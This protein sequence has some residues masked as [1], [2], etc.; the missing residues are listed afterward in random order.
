MKKYGSIRQFFLL[1]IMCCL[2]TLAKADALDALE[3]TLK[4]SP[5]VQ[6]KIYVHT[7]NNMYFVGD[8]LWYK[9]YVVRADNLQPTNM[10][11]LLYV[12][13]LTPD[14][15]LVERQHVVVSAAG[16]TCGQFVLKDS[17]YSGYYEIRAYTRWQLNFNVTEKDYTSD[18]RLKF[19]GKQ[20]AQDF[21]R[22]F[23]G[24]YSRVLPVFEKPKKEGDY[25]DRYMARRPKQHVLKSKTSLV[26]NF[27]PEGGHLVQGVENNVAFEI[28]DNQGQQ[29]DVEGT[30]SD[31]R[32]IRPTHMGR[33]SF[34]VKPDGTQMNVKFEWNGKPVTFRLPQVQKAG[35]V[36]AYDVEKNKATV[37]AT[38]VQPSAYTILCRGRLVKFSRM[39]GAGDINI[40]AEECPTGINEIIVYDQLA[41]P[42]ASRLFFVNHHD[43]GTPVSVG[44]TADGGEVGKTTTL[45]PYAPVELT[46]NVPREDAWIGTMSVAVRD[47]QTDDC[48]YDNG[49]IMTDMLLSSELK[50]FIASPAYY[51]AAD[52]AQ[53]RADLDLLMMVQGW[54]RYKRVEKLRYEPERELAYEGTVFTVPENAD[55][56]ELDDVSNAGSKA[57]TVADQMLAEMDAIS[58]LKGADTFSNVDPNASED[59]ED[60]DAGLGIDPDATNDET[61]EWASTDDIRLG[62]GYVK[63]SVLV[64]AELNKDGEVAGAITHTDKRGHFKITLPAFYDQAI[65]FA[66][67]YNR[68][69]SL[70]K[71]MQGNIDPE[72][73]NERAFPDYFVKRDMFF[74]V[75]SQPYSWYQVNS[76]DLFFVDEGD[77][78]K[79]LEGSRLA[80]NHMLQ[81]VVVSAKRRGKRGIDMKKPAIVMDAYELYNNASDYGLMLG[82]ADFKR[83]P[84]A[85][86]TYFVG[87]MGRRNQ[88]NIRAMV[89]GA[90][91]YRNYTPMV[92]E[93]D[94]PR[95][96]T[97][98]F[99][100]LRLNRIKNVRVYTDYD[101]RTDSGDVVETNAPALTMVFELIPNDAQQYTYRDRRYIFDGLT[102]AEECYSPNYSA[103]VPSKPTDYRRTLYWNPN[104]KVGK[105]G[106]FK[107]TFY[108]NSRETRVTVSAAGMGLALPAQGS[109]EKPNVRLYF[110]DKGGK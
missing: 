110:D 62:N 70:T 89:D 53:H 5:Q 26:C 12:E 92:S 44:L 58:G 105:D 52:D 18:D 1:L 51:F 103:A 39:N 13:L 96:S 27:Y 59:A 75:F 67:A 93:Y 23:E 43:F 95:T 57:T 100:K 74:P 41:Q 94:K 29:Y 9:A 4:N 28:T 107:A 17:L 63:K 21:F 66:K 25:T 101:L 6:E 84:M 31:G 42:L 45:K 48:G 8:T 71:N 69:D 82:V 16:N 86:A 35:A 61:I 98:I 73:T 10:S 102:Y 3:E 14:G 50:G 80:G 87:N 65:L 88:F 56:L 91:F 106:T 79:I 81:T 49:N 72:M 54:R 78:E 108:N 11:K 30:L 90:S 33:G 46:M 55:L 37:R 20:A 64:E 77:D 97:D 24:L 22:N 2:S 99:N 76:P 40:N 109:G 83:M 104:A 19:Y 7:D 47:A 34:T 60:T 32:K 38:G 85:F 15:Y 68:G 36:I